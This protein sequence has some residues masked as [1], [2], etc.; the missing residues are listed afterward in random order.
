MKNYKLILLAAVA[1]CAFSACSG[2]DQTAKNVPDS[3]R[4]PNTFDAPSNQDTFK[5][6]GYMGEAGITEN[7]GNGGTRIVKDTTKMKVR[8]VA[9]AA[10]PAP[11]AGAPAAADS[12]SQKK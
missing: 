6:T 10:T 2:G 12:T 8:S 9:I 5:V 11:A 4:N 1:A 3:V 7:A